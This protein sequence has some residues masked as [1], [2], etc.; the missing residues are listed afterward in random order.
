MVRHGY[1]VHLSH[2]DTVI[3]IAKIDRLTEEGEKAKE[4]I[5]KIWGVIGEC[6]TDRTDAD[7]LQEIEYLLL[8]S[9]K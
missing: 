6:G 1:R 3:L 4:A 2:E 7:K 9:E 5:G 8:C